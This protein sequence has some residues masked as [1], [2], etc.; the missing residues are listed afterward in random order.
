[1]IVLQT[2]CQGRKGKRVKMRSINLCENFR[3]SAK[4]ERMRGRR[5]LN[6][7]MGYSCWSCVTVI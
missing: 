3:L 5:C 4:G 1:M 2:K 7:P 6:P